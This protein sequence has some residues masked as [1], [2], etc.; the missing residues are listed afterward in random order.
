MGRD[1]EARFREPA[2]YD[3]AR[4]AAVEGGAARDWRTH[5]RFV[6]KPSVCEL[7]TQEVPVDGSSPEEGQAFFRWTLSLFQSRQEQRE[8][9]IRLS[10]RPIPSD[11]PLPGGISCRPGPSLR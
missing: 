8:G 2:K 5:G 6:A 4:S 7:E 1:A 9:I 11:D 3:P 10:C